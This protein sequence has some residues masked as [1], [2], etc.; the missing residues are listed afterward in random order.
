VF[1]IN[2]LGSAK[3][4][5]LRRVNSK[6]PDLQKVKKIYKQNNNI[7]MKRYEKKE[8]KWLINKPGGLFL[9]RRSERRFAE[10]IAH[11]FGH[12]LLY[13]RGLPYG[14]TQPGVD[15]FIGRRNS[16]MLKRLGYDF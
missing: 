4:L 13:L 15:S 11:E 16:A 10:R 7:R 12:V 5:S 1:K 2:Y 9:T 8:I 6:S 14:H 3:R